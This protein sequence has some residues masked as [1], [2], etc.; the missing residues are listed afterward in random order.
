MYEPFAGAKQE[1]T[2]LR[3]F[4]LTAESR[5]NAGSERFLAA[6]FVAATPMW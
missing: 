2:F 3:L 1:L 5:L 6:N 4:A